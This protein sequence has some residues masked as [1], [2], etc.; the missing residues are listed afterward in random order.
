MNNE[1]S[2]EFWNYRFEEME[3]DVDDFPKQPDHQEIPKKDFE[4]QTA[5]DELKRYYQKLVGK[6]KDLIPEDVLISN[7]KRDLFSSVRVL[8]VIARYLKSQLPIPDELKNNHRLV[9][10]GVANGLELEN[11]LN[12]QNA[13]ILARHPT[14]PQDQ[15][16]E[17]MSKVFFVA[18]RSL[19]RTEINLPEYPDR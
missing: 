9:V 7:E 17:F 18:S 14:F 2:R 10:F 12:Y 3:L 4:W 8:S 6:H 5:P 19:K 13:V 1:K 15:Y 16:R 11:G